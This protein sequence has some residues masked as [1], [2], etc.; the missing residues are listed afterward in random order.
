LRE[1]TEAALKGVL[2]RPVEDRER[3]VEEVGAL[4]QVEP[5]GAV[6]LLGAATGAYAGSAVAEAGHEAA[7]AAVAA[8]ALDAVAAVDGEPDAAEDE[9]TRAL[10]K[11]LDEALRRCVERLGEVGHRRYTTLTS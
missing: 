3:F 9:R 6:S 8:G 4:A 10:W 7:E 2:R 11:Q 5:E 1:R